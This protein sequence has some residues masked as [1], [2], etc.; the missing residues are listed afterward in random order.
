MSRRLNFTGRK[1]ISRTDAI[2]RLLRNDNTLG[3]VADLRL[4]DYQLG[5]TESAPRVFV[6]AYRSAS[7]LWKRFDFGRIGTI[8]AP[9]ESSLEEFGAPDG[10]LFRVKVSADGEYLGKLLAE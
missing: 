9:A 6:E 10:I 5:D 3:F 1:K 4:G 2:I 8:K 7:M